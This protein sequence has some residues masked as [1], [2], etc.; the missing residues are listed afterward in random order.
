MLYRPK[1]CAECGERIMRVDWPLFASRRF[2][3]LCSSIN[4]GADLLPRV[5]AAI[6][7]VIGLLGIGIAMR[8]S[9]KPRTDGRE[10]ARRFSA[11]PPPQDRVPS[12]LINQAPSPP[13]TPVAVPEQRMVPTVAAPPSKTADIAAPM[14]PVEDK[15]LCGA[16][17]K[18]GTPC[19]RRVKGPKRCYQHEGMP[20][21]VGQN[22]LRVK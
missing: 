5:V 17:T 19:S 11:I 18:K 2:C 21:I 15:Y 12:A 6:G 3:E 16:Q 9:I 13:A 10:E 14:P 8:T 7:I 1:F 22:E 20:A 4:K